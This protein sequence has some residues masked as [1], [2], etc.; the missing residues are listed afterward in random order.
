MR[1]RDVI[2]GLGAASV[3]IGRSFAQ[4]LKRRIGILIPFRP[5]YP[6]AAAW[7][8]ALRK[9]LEAAGWF[10]GQTASF[11]FQWTGENPDSMAA[12][13]AEL[14]RQAPD[15]VFVHG[16]PMLTAARK[17]TDSIPLIFVQVPDA[18]ESGFV[19]SF[20]QP[21]GNITGF[22]N[23]DL[24]TGGKWIE[25]LKGVAPSIL[26]VLI[27]QDAENPSWK[28]H[29]RAIEA[30][31]PAAGLQLLPAAV[32]DGPGIERAVARFASEGGGGCVALPSPL[33]SAKRQ[34]LL[35]AV[36]GYK[37]PTVYPF[38]T[39][40]RRGGLLSYGTDTA[41]LYRRAGVYIDRILRGA[42]VRDLPVQ[43]PTRFELVINLKAAEALGLTFPPSILAQ[44]D[45]VIE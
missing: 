9:A 41:D 37:V 28:P 11:A 3:G 38:S 17:A 24:N 2:A 1:R 34:V 30:A 31:A 7:V 16:V 25:L 13:A 19:S 21:S 10:E 42:F 26:R 15:V 27:L 14:V 18:V 12:A 33:L 35:E 6:D 45:E 32:A 22:T 39:F 8:S 40:T 29:M 5:E 44:A 36:A 20:A 43:Q 23:F 4:P